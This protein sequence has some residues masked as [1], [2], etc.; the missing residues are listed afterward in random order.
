MAVAALSARA[1]AEWARADGRPVLALDAFGDADTRRAAARWAGI[2]SAEG[3]RIDGQRLLAELARP[4]LQ[5][6]VAGSGFEAQPELLEAAARRLPLRGTAPAQRRRLQTAREFIGQLRRLGLAHPETR[7][8]PPVSPQGWL[9]KG[10]GGCGG[11]A[12]RAAE[13]RAGVVPGCWQRRLAGRPMSATFVADGERAVILGF[14]SQWTVAQG[15]TPCL[16]AG[17]AS[18]VAV[19]EG[20]RA[21][22]EQA[23]A[24]LVPEFE[25]RGL[26]SL[27]FLLAEGRPWWLEVNARPPASADHYPAADGASPLALHL[28][29]CEGAGLPPPGP[30]PVAGPT[31]GLRVVRARQALRLDAAAVAWLGHQ[32]GVHDLPSGPQALP[33]GAPVCTVSAT[34]RDEHA[35]LED[36]L[37]R[38]QRLLNRLE[39]RP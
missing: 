26:G 38:E 25:L 11:Q 21:E 8:E 2:G 1:L 9:F 34:G 6:W 19:S 28:R 22:A 4:G 33:A 5:A 7:F 39:T 17:L 31:R 27:D 24:V 29:A 37:A 10:D 32:A 13:A 35:V 23:L 14:N 16:F 15:D 36:L 20:V 12:V 18:G 3:L 30:G